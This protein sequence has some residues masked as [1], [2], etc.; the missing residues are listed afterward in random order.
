MVPISFV[1]RGENKLSIV[2]VLSSNSLVFFLLLVTLD[3]TRLF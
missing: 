3:L 2:I 1:L